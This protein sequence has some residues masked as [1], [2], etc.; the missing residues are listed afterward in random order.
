MKI[1][2]ELL[3]ILIILFMLIFWKIWNSFSRKK[4]L[5]KYKPENDKARRGTI[6][7]PRIRDSQGRSDEGERVIETASPDLSR[8]AEPKGRELLPKAEVIS[9]GEDNNSVGEP[10]KHLGGNKRTL[11]ELFKRR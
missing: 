5:K 9:P 8:P 4:L 2:I 6:F 7:N 10:S 1:Y 3:I 11:R